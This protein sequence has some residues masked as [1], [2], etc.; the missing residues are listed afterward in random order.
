MKAKLFS[1][2]IGLVAFGHTALAQTTGYKMN[3]KMNDGSFFS[4]PADDVNEV[5]FTATEEKQFTDTYYTVGGKAEKG[6]FKSGSAVT[7]QP[8][9]LSLNALGSAQTTMTFD[10]CG[11]Y[12]FRNMLFKYPYVQ[13]SATGLFYNEVD[14]YRTRETQV[15]LQGY[16]DLQH[17]SK[18]NVNVV[19]HLIAERIANLTIGGIDF[20]VAI[21]QAQGELLSAFGLQRLNDKD[22]SQ[23]SI[24]DGDDYAAALLAISMPL[25]Y[26]RKGDE[27][28]SWMTRLRYDFADDG[29]FTEQN[30]QQFCQDRNNISLSYDVEQLV[31]KYGEYGITIN[32]KDLRYFYDWDNDGVAGNEIYDPSQPATYDVTNIHAPMEGGTYTVHV[33]CNVPLYTSPLNSGDV[34][35]VYNPWGQ[36]VQT[37]MSVS[38][39]Y[40]NGTWTIKVNPAQYR[41]ISDTNVCLY[42]AVGNVVAT[43]K[44]SQDGN[45]DGTFLV[46]EGVYYVTEICRLLASSHSK[47]RIADAKYTG[48][49]DNYDFK[50]P[51]DPSDYNVRELFSN[52]YQMINR[53]AQLLRMASETG[54]DALNPMCFVTNAL[55]YYELVTMFGAVPYI[56]T[57]QDVYNIPRTSPDEIFS[58]LIQD[59]TSIIDRLSDVKG[60]YIDNVDGIALPPKDFARIVLAD[61]YMYQGN[62]SAAK[63]LLAEIVSGNRYSLT[64]TQNNIDGTCPEIIWSQPPYTPTRARTS[65]ATDI[66]IDYDSPYCIIKTYADVLLSLAECESKFGNESKAKEYLDEVKTAKSIETTSSDVIAAISEVRSKIQVDFGGYFAFLKRTGLAQS[67]LGLEEYQLLFPIPQEQIWVNPSMTQNPGYDGNNGG[68]R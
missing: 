65:E 62:Y 34:N 49:V 35:S 36:Y 26:D 33:S 50:A 41:F 37:Y 27:L 55:M 57:E 2:M 13:L 17:G 12:S 38:T 9:D 47:Y 42:D 5:Y 21:S 54:I 15:T 32:V 68:T 64:S 4:V 43:V 56:T 7:M 59:L 44:L 58:H 66:V 20:D 8:L 22:F 18:V 40:A 3:V 24:T 14:D 29:K 51:L 60:G 30:K 48:V 31:E 23:V 16:A 53:N 6:P 61:I 10:D 67:V 52:P 45:P 1:M 19:T 39:E 63:T 46:N 11:N 25:L 28:I